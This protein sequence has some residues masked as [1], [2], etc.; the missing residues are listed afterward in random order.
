M[1]SYQSIT[2]RDEFIQKFRQDQGL[3]PKTPKNSMIPLSGY[4]NKYATNQMHRV[5]SSE[6]INRSRAQV[7]F[8]S[9]NLSYCRTSNPEGRWEYLHQ[10]EKLKRTKLDQQRKLKDHELYMKDVNECTFS[11]KLNTNKSMSLLSP[12]PL[13]SIGYSSGTRMPN[14][15]NSS[16]LNA[17]NMT[18]DTLLIRQQQWNYKKNMR[19]EN[20]KQSQILN[21]NKECIFKPKLVREIMRYLI[22]NF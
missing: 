12:K 3:E 17:I 1:N 15:P 13:S 19:I 11:P 10:L 5:Q 20:I 21:D 6:K 2:N 9:N 22:V 4:S 18:S 16:S 8:S 14:S 7:N